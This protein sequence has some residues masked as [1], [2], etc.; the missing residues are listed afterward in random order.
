MLQTFA[1]IPVVG[2]YNN[3]WNWLILI[4]NLIHFDRKFAIL[5]PAEVVETSK[6]SR[7]LI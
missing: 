3:N 6:I 1:L 2:I 4:K 5:Y 7:K